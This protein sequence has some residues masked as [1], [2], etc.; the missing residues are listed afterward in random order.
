MELKDKILQRLEDNR[1]EYVSG[2]SLS[3][4]A[5][6]SRQAVWKAVKKLTAEGYLISSATNRGYM[7]DGKCDMLS[8]SVI[9]SKTGAAVECYDCVPSTNAVAKK[10]LAEIGECII[11]SDGQSDGKTKDGG[12]FYS[13]RGKGV[14]FS[15][16]LPLNLPLEKTDFL[17]SA[18]GE[19]VARVIQKTCERFA[20]VVR[21]DEIFID[22]K[23]V[24]GILTECEFCAATK[25]I[26]SAVIGVG[27]YTC[28]T[29]FTQA[30][31]ASVFPDDTRNNMVAEIYTSIKKALS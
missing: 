9:A 1:G 4:D 16:A 28:E 31:F 22:G 27:I 24:A 26:Q 2:E 29:C 19:A 14:Y 18:C 21:L 25:I 11:V 15:I 7:L 12:N 17:R 23:K 6:V 20:K 5:G 13:P 3:F 8:A 30:G 10:K